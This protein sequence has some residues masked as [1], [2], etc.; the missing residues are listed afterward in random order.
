MK[1]AIIKFCKKHRKILFLTGVILIVAAAI[2]P[3]LAFAQTVAAGATPAASPPVISKGIQD[4]QNN[5]LNAAQQLMNLLNRI[6]WPVLLLIGGL[7]KTDLLYSAGMEDRLLTIWGAM[8][9][10]VNI[11]FVIVLL[12]IAFYNVMGGSDQG[13]QIK[14]VLPKFVIGLILVNFS[15][16][17]LKV[18]LD[19]VN[20]ISTAVFSLPATTTT[21][22]G[23]IPQD[24]DFQ[25]QVCIGIYGNFDTNNADYQAAVTAAGPDN[26]LCEVETPT[27]TSKATA[28]FQRYDGSNAAIV[29]AINLAKVTQLDNVYSK[30]NIQLKDLALNSLFSLIFYIIYAVAFVC[31]LVVLVARLVA[32]YLTII[33]S[34]FMA[35]TY[36][37]PQGIMGKIGGDTNIK[38]MFVQN[39]IIPIPIALV[40]TIGFIMIQGFKAAKFS[41]LSLSSPGLS[42][43][44]L[45]SGTTTLQDIIAGVAM[46]A[47]LWKGIFAAMDKSI[48]KGITSG[49][50]SSVEGTAK[51]VGGSWKYIPFFPVQAGKGEGEKPTM[52]SVA[53]LEQVQG[54]LSNAMQIRA[55]DEA[56]M[57]AKGAFGIE[58]GTYPEAI[59]K[60]KTAEE[61]RG[62]LR[63]AH[64]HNQSGEKEVQQAVGMAMKQNPGRFESMQV[65]FRPGEF[66]DKDKKSIK[67]WQEFKKKMEDGTVDPEDMKKFTEEATKGVEA[68]K[69]SEGKPA[70]AVERAKGKPAS[71]EKIS[72]ESADR[73]LAGAAPYE[74]S[75]LLTTD[76]QSKVDEYKKTP[77][78]K[79]AKAAEDPK[80]QKALTKLKRAGENKNK[81]LTDI[82]GAKSLNDVQT[83]IDTR[84]KQLREVANAGDTGGAVT[85]ES[86]DQMIQSEIA[87]SPNAAKNVR[88]Y[89]AGQPEIMKYAPEELTVPTGPAIPPGAGPVTP[90][91]A[92]QAA[93]QPGVPAPAARPAAPGRTAPAAQ[94]APVKPSA[95]PTTGTPP[96]AAPAKPAATPPA[97][98]PPPTP[99][100]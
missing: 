15:F 66:K 7:M 97:A 74:N 28:L 75:P 21:E 94:S 33:L 1:T 58:G 99:K 87:Q 19:G 22:K 9:D 20:V 65:Y 34:P 35:L 37:L 38:D 11:L 54:K 61:L 44:L 45:V 77:A 51:F 3:Q 73:I 27:F 100:P 78:D 26:A 36:V 96:P 18:V 92:P 5:I 69:I 63:D 67:N 83:A 72:Q 91:A 30:Q 2:L 41:S 85:D 57:L 17:G 82:A 56:G 32:L 71:V 62:T 98:T 60:A 29:M 76:E 50:K 89:G 23:V 81:P 70:T 46:V 14:T 42:S 49:I 93:G 68:I 40:M 88:Q 55:S 52:I 4:M 95:A 59:R 10:L 90:T 12:G 80:L 43:N 86:I 64:D 8:R 16:V 47:F 31:L 24:A 48:A 79:K 13:F 6:L 53:G 25:K 84:K 39:A